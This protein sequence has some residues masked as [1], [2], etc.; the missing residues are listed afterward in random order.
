MSSPSTLPNPKK[1]RGNRQKN[2]RKGPKPKADQPSRNNQQLRDWPNETPR[3]ST[4][5]D[6]TPTDKDECDLGPQ[7]HLLSKSNAEELSKN[8]QESPTSRENEDECDLG[9]Q[10]HLLSKST[11]EELSKNRQES[12]T[13]R[14]NEDECDLGPQGHLLSKSNAEELSKNRQES[15]SSRENASIK[16]CPCETKHPPLSDATQNKD[17]AAREDGKE[18][19][20][21]PFRWG[22]YI[23]EVSSS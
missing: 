20:K 22:P 14:E 5:R 18:E 10:G 15:P 23:P 4:S 1:M 17:G 7:G 16:K 6:P 12:P 8:R 2:K 9:P 11:A 19:V 3:P 13:S 21:D